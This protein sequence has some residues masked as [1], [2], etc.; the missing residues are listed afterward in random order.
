M[1]LP[2]TAAKFIL[3]FFHLINPEREKGLAD[4]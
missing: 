3:V 2:F 4:K 1:L